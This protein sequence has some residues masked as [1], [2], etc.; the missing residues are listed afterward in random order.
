MPH[1][2]TVENSATLWLRS[3]YESFLGRRS[4]RCRFGRSPQAILLRRVAALL[5][6]ANDA[7][8]IYFKI[9]PGSYL[10]QLC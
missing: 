2:A 5:N 10:T 6:A 1:V 8:S 9:A 7:D 4:L 3:F